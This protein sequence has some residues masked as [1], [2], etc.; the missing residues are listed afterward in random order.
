[1]ATY[2]YWEI[3]RDVY[4][5]L[6]KKKI[7]NY[8]SFADM[9]R[10][11][12][13]RFWIIMGGIIISLVAF[14]VLFIACPNKFWYLIPLVFII[15]FIIYSEFFENKMYNSSERKKEL[16]KRNLRLEQYLDDVR[17]VLQ[18]HGIKTTEQI[19]ILKEEC[20]K[21]IKTHNAAFKSIS[22]KTYDMLIGVPLGAFISALI[23]NDKG[24]EV[25][26]N[27]FSL[28]IIGFTIIGI[29]NIFKKISYYSSGNFKDKFLLDVICE[30]EYIEIA[31]KNL[32]KHQ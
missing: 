31:S 20:E 11:F 23:Y 22:S 7:K 5:T 28:I 17:E 21:Q 18:S 10:L 24:N 27:I 13:C 4:D 25:I 8:R 12:A 14:L 30:L 1:M 29:A 6:S 3:Q 15:G 9:K 26:I 19:A 32:Y 16:G 2:R